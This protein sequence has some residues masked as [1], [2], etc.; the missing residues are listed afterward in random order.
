MPPTLYEA[1][2]KLAVQKRQTVP[3]YIRRLIWKHIDEEDIPVSIYQKEE[4]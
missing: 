3:A 2:K 4:H 1:V